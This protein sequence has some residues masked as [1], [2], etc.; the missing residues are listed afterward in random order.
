MLR[1]FKRTTPQLGNKFYYR[2]DMASSTDPLKILCKLLSGIGKGLD[3]EWTEDQ[4]KGI[5]NAVLSEFDEARDVHPIEI[6]KAYDLLEWE[7]RV[8]RRQWDPK[9]PT[10]EPLAITDLDSINKR[11]DALEDAHN[12]EVAVTGAAISTLTTLTSTVES[13]RSEALANEAIITTLKSKNDRLEA[14]AAASDARFNALDTRL[15]KLE[16]LFQ[17]QDQAQH[18]AVIS[19]LHDLISSKHPGTKRGIDH[20]DGPGSGDQARL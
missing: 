17:A 4:H 8:Q 15:D 2:K 13:H 19:T 7:T 9:T 14:Q 6:G 16:E 18:D 1:V 10:P 20:P 11:V 12:T 5:K 3:C